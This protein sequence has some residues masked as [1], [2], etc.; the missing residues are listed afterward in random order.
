MSNNTSQEPNNNYDEAYKL[1]ERSNIDPA[2][3]ADLSLLEDIQGNILKS[4]GRNYSIYLFLHFDNQQLEATKNW[5]GDFA[6]KYVG[7]ATQQ[8]AQSRAYKK[9]LHNQNAVALHQNLFANFSL[10]FKGY[11]ALSLDAKNHFQKLY[12]QKLE[13]IEINLPSL[14]PFE[15]GM[16]KN[17][18]TLNDTEC[19]WEAEYRQKDREI[20]A[21]ILLADDDRDSLLEAANRIVTA[22]AESSIKIVK[23]EIGFVRRNDLNQTVEPFGFADGIS[24]PLFLKQDI[25]KVKNTDKWNPSANLRLVLNVDPFGKKFTDKKGTRYSFGS[26]LVYRK[27]EQNVAGFNH[28]VTELARKLENQVTDSPPQAETEQLVRAYSMGRFREDGRPVAMYANLDRPEQSEIELNNFNYGEGSEFKQTSQWKCPFHAHIRKVTSRAI[29][30]KVYSGTYKDSPENQRK[31]RIVRRGTTYGLPKEDG[32]F[33]LSAS[34]RENLAHYQNLSE[35]LGVKLKEGKEGT[36]FFCFQSDIKAQFEKLQE[37][38]NDRDFG[39]N[40]QGNLGADPIV[41]QQGNKKKWPSQTWPSKWGD[42]KDPVRDDSFFGVVT[43]RGGEYFFTPS[44]S[45]L[46]SLKVA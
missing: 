40:S 28:G 7:S 42:R 24:Q 29:S 37:Y 30:D 6:Q 11:E 41:G 9:E 44:L 18:A 17:L 34:T 32:A 8:A 20:H 14:H 25:E 21:L 2:T 1:L 26:F 4:H 5:I 43:P 10:S 15:Q 16:L 35:Q 33:L 19:D 31:R 39:P 23:K 46:Y 3:E 27:L 36:L 13:P 45:F 22:L 38:A 12:Q